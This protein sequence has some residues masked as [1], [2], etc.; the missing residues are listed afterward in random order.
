M[1]KYKHTALNRL[2]TPD[3]YM[4]SSF[5]GSSFLKAY[6][7]DRLRF[8]EKFRGLDEK[9]HKPQIPFWLHSK[10]L[11]ALRKKLNANEKFYTELVG[12]DTHLDYNPSADN[13][14]KEEM[15]NVANLPFFDISNDINTKDL[16]TSLLANQL[17]FSNSNLVKF[18]LDRLVQR[19][20]V[21]KKIYEVYPQ[22]FSKGKGESKTICLYWMF[23]LS[24]IF[25]Y[26]DTSSVKYLNTLLKVIDLLCSLDD[27]ILIDSVP[28]QSMSFVLL[29]EMINIRLLSENIEGLNY[30]VK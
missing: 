3:N 8:L 6:Y 18:W 16:L 13:Y 26:E 2:I 5:E 11:S 12:K 28:S 25:Y 15:A 24:L 1:I 29:V 19:F 22:N 17:V 10:T 23:S 30:D 14:S 21:T 27:R 9:N 7:N 4:Y 20:E